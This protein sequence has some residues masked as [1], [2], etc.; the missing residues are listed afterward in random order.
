MYYVYLL[1]S[2]IRDEIYVG[3]TNNLKRRVWEHNMGL[4]ESTKHSSDW[5]RK[6]SK[7]F[8]TRSE[9]M[10]FEKYLKS[11]KSSKALRKII[12]ES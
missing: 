4:S 6:F 1:K 9:A 2:K 11:L 12:L 8:E 5:E 7:I 3:S 10:K